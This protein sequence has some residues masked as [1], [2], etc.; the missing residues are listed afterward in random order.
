MSDRVQELLV[1]GLEALKAGLSA[2]SLKCT[3]WPYILELSKAQYE[4]DWV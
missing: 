3:V 1:R 4:L 2:N